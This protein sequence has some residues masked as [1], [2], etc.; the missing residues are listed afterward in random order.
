MAMTKLKQVEVKGKKFH[1]FVNN[2]GSFFADFDGEQVFAES[3]KQLTDK[4]A[5]RIKRAKRVSI[6]ICMWEKRDWSD[7]R[8]R[9]WARN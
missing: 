3:L 7:E 4:L 1:I 6:P 5:S 8:G 9:V 2:E